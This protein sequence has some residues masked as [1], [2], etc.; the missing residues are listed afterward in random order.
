MPSFR[1]ARIR[2]GRQ[3]DETSAGNL[4]LVVNRF[5]LL[6]GAQQISVPSPIFSRIL[7]PTTE[8][9]RADVPLCVMA[10]A[11]KPVVGA[12]IEEAIRHAAGRTSAE[13]VSRRRRY[14]KAHDIGLVFVKA[15]NCRWQI[16]IQVNKRANDI[17][18][19]FSWELPDAID[20]D[21]RIEFAVAVRGFR[22][23]K[24][25][26]A[27]RGRLSRK[28]NDVGMFVHQPALSRCSMAMRA[29]MV[30]MISLF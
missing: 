28:A 24:V 30:L 21:D 26:K 13:T 17:F 9:L 8:K 5:H 27:A 7:L 22:F 1:W 3:R 2:A 16:P 23:C 4:R 10:I 12:V 6:I 18:E 19:L 25:G 29:R 20:D 14:R 11:H 15:G